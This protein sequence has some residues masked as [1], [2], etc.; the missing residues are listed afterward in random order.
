MAQGSEEGKRITTQVLERVASLEGAVSILKDFIIPSTQPTN[1]IQS[2]A[3]IQPTTKNIIGH[4]IMKLAT[5]VWEFTKH[6]LVLM[7]LPMAVLL[8]LAAFGLNYDDINKGVQWIRD[9]KP[10]FRIVERHPVTQ[11][12]Q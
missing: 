9:H 4:S 12:H 7:L 3:A 11:P 10:E 1:P 2:P 6:P 8:I 5:V